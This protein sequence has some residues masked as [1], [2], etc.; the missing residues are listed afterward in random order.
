M[1]TFMV[2][3]AAAA[4][5]LAVGCNDKKAPESPTEKSPETPKKQNRELDDRKAKVAEPTQ[6]P[7]PVGGPST[8]RNRGVDAPPTEEPAP[9]PE[10][11]PEPAVEAPPTV[12]EE[13]AVEAAGVG[14]E[15]PPTVE[16]PKEEGL[17]FKHL[18]EGELKKR[19]RQYVPVRIS[20][21]ESLLSDN[22][23][24]II[25]KLVQAANIM[26]VL[27]W[28][29]ASPQ[30]LEWRRKLA[31]TKTP[32]ARLLFHY[33][34]V[35][36]GPWDRLANFEAFL[37][38]EEKPL[39]GTFYP[40]DMTKEEFDQWIADHPDQAEA[41]KSNFTVI[42]RDGAGLKAVPYSEEHKRELGAATKALQDAAALANDKTL[43]KFL[44]SRAAA[45]A[46]D[47][48]MQSDMDWMDLDSRIEVTIGPYEVYEDRLMGYKAAF[49]AFV[50]VKDPEATKL[51]RTF[52]KWAGKLEK[53]LPIDDKYKNTNRGKSSPIVVVDLLYSA[54]D[55]RAGVQTIAFN[56]PNDE[57]VREAKGS[58]KVLL[59][60][61]MFAKFEKILRPIAAEVLTVDL[62]GSLNREAFF[63][64]TLMHEISHG[65][66]P[67][68]IRNA[69]GE[70][71]TVS[72][73]L[74][75]IYPHLEEAKADI[76]GLYNNLLLVRKGV[77]KIQDV[78][79]DKDGEKKR[80]LS[81]E[82]ARR[83]LAATFLAGIFRSV[84]F[85]TEEAHGKANLLIL[86]HLVKGGAFVWDGEKERYR[87]AWDKLESATEACAK[88]LLMI[89]A[90]GDY[91]AGAAFIEEYGQRSPELETVLKKFADLP[92]DVEP[93][94]RVPRVEN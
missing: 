76:L 62:L 18:D 29:Q 16:E 81:K 78:V 40:Q 64:H 50:T 21:D 91:A 43:K 46:S 48:Y 82:D 10:P 58:K 25:K 5:V 71:T 52:S 19:L 60:N 74:K 93:V 44:E 22:D 68:K 33:L 11:E 80:Q 17:G 15:A 47:D 41:F 67:G 56:L 65:I 90:L 94:F 12:E 54:G 4:L 20:V 14:A 51:L 36:Y 49:E 73:A 6:E 70:D 39:G 61:I 3:V 42:R 28:K 77:E 34:M 88:D 92:I 66:G 89:E 13:P 9:E 37:G 2:L 32:V 24:R 35:N 53:E 31:Q 38:E 55:T 7:D 57:R 23:K 30:G 75:E 27:F 63:N 59:R 86:N 69:A 72:L 1:R 87:V 45:F 85:G 26:D 8:G 84:R 79:Q 83:A